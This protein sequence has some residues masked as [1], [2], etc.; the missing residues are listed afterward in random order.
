[1]DSVFLFLGLTNI[2]KEAY[3]LI[4]VAWTF[5]VNKKN[6]LLLLLLWRWA[7]KGLE[8]VASPAEVI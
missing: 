1:M 5:T 4:N 3:T 8:S 2:Q 6:V 7:S